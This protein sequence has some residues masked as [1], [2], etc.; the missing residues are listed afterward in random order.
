MKQPPKLI[1]VY[2]KQLSV[3]PRN[4]NSQKIFQF[5]YDVKKRWTVMKK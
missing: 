4:H 5:K 1:K 3:S 2:L